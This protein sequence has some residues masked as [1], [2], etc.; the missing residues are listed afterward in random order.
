MLL[1]R[2]L[3]SRPGGARFGNRFFI[4]GKYKCLILPDECFKPIQCIGGATGW[5]TLNWLWSLRGFI[6]K[7]AGGVGSTRA[8]RNPQCLLPGDTIDFWRVDAIEQ[9]RM[10]RLFS[11]LKAPGR[12]WLQI[13]VK[14]ADIQFDHQADFN[15]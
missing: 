11:E 15:F 10:L 12:A 9:D 8:R 3:K 14:A 1:P 13:E 7:I 5:Y 2:Y 6:D 4:P